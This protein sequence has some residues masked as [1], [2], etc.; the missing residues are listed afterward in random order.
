MNSY[1]LIKSE[2]NVNDMFFRCHFFYKTHR[3]NVFITQDDVLMSGKDLIKNELF[4]IV[5]IKKNICKKHTY[6]SNELLNY[7]DDVIK[8]INEL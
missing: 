3:K 1:E 7:K 2:K 4:L 5:F 8:I 6:I